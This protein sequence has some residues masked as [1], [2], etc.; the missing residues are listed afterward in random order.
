MQPEAGKG[1]TRGDPFQTDG[2]GRWNSKF[3]CLEGRE[4]E[5][6]LW[7]GGEQRGGYGR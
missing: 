7:E 3:R 1:K 6:Q 5:G 4:K 2:R